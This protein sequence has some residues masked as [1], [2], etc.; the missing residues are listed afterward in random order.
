MAAT[1]IVDSGKFKGTS[2]IAST[3]TVGC[4]YSLFGDKQ[5]RISFSS[6][7]EFAS[8]DTTSS[9]RPVV[10][11]AVTTQEDGS[12]DLGVIYTAG[13][14]GNDLADNHGVV[15]V[16]DDGSSVTFTYA[17]RN[18]DGTP[19]HGAALCTKVLRIP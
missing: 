19:F 9:G 5:W 15:T 1:V 16:Q 8:V 18:N 14:N 6:D 2:R 13:Q 7:G 12:A 3:G 10:S 17:G 11:F 4:S